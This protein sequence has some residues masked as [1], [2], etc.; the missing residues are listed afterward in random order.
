MLDFDVQ[1]FTRVCAKTDRELKAGDAFYSYLV[2]DGSETVR[3][4]VCEQAWEGPPDECLGWWKSEVPDP[5]STKL[6][7]APHDV[8][9]HY[10]TE[11]E[12]KPDQL[13]LRYVLALLMVRRRIFRLE[14]SKP[15]DD[16]TETLTLFCS[17]NDTEYEVP[18][19]DVTS[20][21]A[22]ELQA[23]VSE[24]LVDVGK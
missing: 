12:D 10:F 24:L 20:E 19:V 18:V 9:L 16:G 3:R 8:M 1:K 5:K 23:L 7:W 17:R 6:N 2:R 21:R 15:Q 14:E 13:D 4:D 11:T 22:A